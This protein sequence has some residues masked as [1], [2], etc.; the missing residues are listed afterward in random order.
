MVEGPVGHDGA[1][2]DTRVVSLQSSVAVRD[3]EVVGGRSMSVP[4][5]E[6]GPVVVGSV[7]EV[8]VVAVVVGDGD[9]SSMCDM[10]GP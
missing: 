3:V 7:G 2:E 10:E 6:E 8:Q 5:V 9:T 1:G 4:G